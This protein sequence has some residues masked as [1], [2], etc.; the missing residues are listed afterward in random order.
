MH[1]FWQ[2]RKLLP[3]PMIGKDWL[4]KSKTLPA[5][6]LVVY[7]FDKAWLRHAV[8]SKNLLVLV[9]REPLMVGPWYLE[10]NWISIWNLIHMVIYPLPSVMVDFM[11]SK[12]CATLYIHLK[13]VFTIKC[14]LLEWKLLIQAY[15]FGHK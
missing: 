12:S 5:D 4:L 11:L 3:I 7:C 14:S 10:C 1:Q 9:F 2:K 6:I 15:T 8:S 13:I